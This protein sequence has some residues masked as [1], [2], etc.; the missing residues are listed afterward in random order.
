MATFRR[1]GHRVQETT[2]SG[3]SGTGP[4]QLNGTPDTVDG[5]QTFVAE[6]GNGQATV[7]EVDDGAGSWERG[8][9]IVTNAS[10][11][12]ISRDFVIASSAGGS[13][14]NFSAGV[15]DVYIPLGVE[16]F[17][18]VRLL[19]SSTT[20]D[21]RDH[22][23]TVRVSAFSAAVTITLPDASTVPAGE[24]YP[25]YAESATNNITI[26]ENGGS[27]LLVLTTDK[28]Y[29]EFRSTGVTWIV[30]AANVQPIVTTFTSST[31]WNRSPG[32]FGIEW[33]VVGGGG[34]GGGAGTTGSGQVSVGA[35]GGAGGYTRLV[36]DAT[37]AGDSRAITIGS[38]GSGGSGANS[39][40]A[41]GN[42][43]VGI[44]LQA[45]G[46][47]GGLSLLAAST[48]SAT[49][50]GTGGSVTTAGDVQCDGGAGS[51]AIRQ[52]DMGAALT[53]FGGSIQPH[54]SGARG[55][56][57]FGGNDGGDGNGQGGGG[58]GAGNGPSQGSTRTGGAGTSGLVIVREYVW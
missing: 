38:G 27:D 45:D 42:T 11:D 4:I 36:T 31:T 33:E 15:K 10:P 53:G 46:G 21:P 43:S 29:A 50:G 18:G 32:R 7:Y 25:V 47:S 56:A 24:T 37:T 17:D 12:T 19:T 51:I 52:T 16:M 58:S 34:G 54:G 28:D 49:N 22:N 40:S 9:G 1:G 8:V 35:G 57:V 2:T 26:T 41:G 5:I 44:L 23:R 48:L 6:I 3:F 39:G 13:K 14:V 55:N 20:L 30:Q